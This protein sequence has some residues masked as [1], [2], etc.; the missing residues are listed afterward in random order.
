MLDRFNFSRIKNYLSKDLWLVEKD[1]LPPLKRF[2]VNALQVIFLTIK[3]FIHDKCD[4]KASGLTYYSLLSIVPI[5]ALAFAIAKGFGYDSALEA[6]IYSIF[7]GHEL[8]AHQ[9]VEFANKM[10]SET[11]TGIIAVS[12]LFVLLYSVMSLLYN[13]EEI[14]NQVWNIKTS[15]PIGRKLT[16]YFAI[17]LVGPLFIIASSSFT[18]YL[19]SEIKEVTSSLSVLKMASPIIFV[20]LKWVPYTLVWF[21]FTLLFMVMP[22]TK[23]SFK[24]AIVAG[25]F[26]GTL[27]QLVQ[28]GLIN[29]QIGVSRYNAIYGS[30][31]VLPLFLFW[32][33]LS[34]VIVLLGTELSYAIQ[35]VEGNSYIKH[36]L[37]LSIA[38]EKLLC[39]A[40][41]LEVVKRFKKVEKAANLSDLHKVLGVP[42]I[43]INQ[44][45]EVLEK[46]NLL[47]LVENSEK[48]AQFLPAMDLASI[49]VFDVISRLD[50]LDNAGVDFS[51]YA[52]YKLL[53]DKLEGI[54]E[55]LLKNEGGDLISDF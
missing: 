42:S 21:A 24:A 54:K 38:E 20:A 14:F 37:K 25:V 45:V 23:V 26:A 55:R 34:W 22:N 12:G 9:A 6:E 2:F 36:K 13:I 15:R 7:S 27:Y 40:V 11:K 4:L 44:V 47:I 53:V 5:L 41:M 39:L 49:R 19:V 51:K 10:L 29:F 48:Q 32:L 52:N 31:A 3:E 16:D 43:Y 1:A 35:H 46:S 18:V 50:G 8:V 30:F 33:Q 17:M 28:W